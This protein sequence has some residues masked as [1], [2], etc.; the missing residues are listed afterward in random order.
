MWT[1]Y[2]LLSTCGRFVGWRKT[3]VIILGALHMLN[4]HTIP[5]KRHP[6]AMADPNKPEIPVPSPDEPELEP[7]KAEPE[8]DPPA[9]PEPEL[10]PRQPDEVPPAEPDQPEIPAPGPDV[11]E[12]RGT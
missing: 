1:T 6:L 5:Q 11:P 10:P 3:I 4:Q 2:S 9:T 7:G 8:M 12:V